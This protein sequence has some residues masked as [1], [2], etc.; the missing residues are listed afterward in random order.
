MRERRRPVRR[1]AIYPMGAAIDLLSLAASTSV[2]G[3]RAHVGGD[4]WDARHPPAGAAR[5]TGR[6]RAVDLLSLAI[7]TS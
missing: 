5:R 1:A 2:I 6:R 7:G 3:V 4:T